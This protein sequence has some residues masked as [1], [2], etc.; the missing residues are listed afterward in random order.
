M[1]RDKITQETSIDWVMRHEQTNACWQTT[2]MKV[3]VPE[4]N[5]MTRNDI[6]WFLSPWS[7]GGHLSWAVIIYHSAS[8]RYVYLFSQYLNLPETTT[9]SL[10]YATY[11]AQKHRKRKNLKL[12]W[13]KYNNNNT[14][15]VILCHLFVSLFVSLVVQLRYIFI[16]YWYY[17]F[18]FYLWYHLSFYF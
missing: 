5:K 13:R 7:T 8:L 15:C 4:W 2:K 18:S 14:I 3:H 11:F 9:V 16:Q 17:Y 10:H 12:S 6:S 1:H